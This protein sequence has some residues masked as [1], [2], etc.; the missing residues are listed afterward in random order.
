MS[1]SGDIKDAS[2]RQWLVVE[3]G[4]TVTT[5]AFLATLAE[6]LV[7][8]GLPVDRMLLSVRT[9]HP[10][11][12]ATGYLWNAGH[13]VVEVD[14]SYDILNAPEYL[15][16]PFRMIHEG[17]ARVRR[18]LT[19]P[20]AC[21][22]MPLMTELVREGFTDYVGLQFVMS[23]GTRDAISMATRHPD[24]FTDEQID[25]L[26][27]LTPIISLIVDRQSG[28]RTARTLLDTYVGHN[29]GERILKGEIRRGM[30][31]R[32]QAVIWYGDLRNFT[33]MSDS[34]PTDEVIATLDEYFELMT[35]AVHSH[36]G[37]VLKYIGDGIL[38]IFEIGD[39]AFRHYACRQA[40]AAA[41]EV[42]EGIAALNRVRDTEG[43]PPLDFGLGLH[44]GELV[45]GNIGSLDRLDFTV[46]G[47]AV[48]LTSRL[49][50]LSSQLG[51]TIL[52]SR[53]FADT[54]STY[55]PFVSLGLHE[56]RGV[57]EPQEVFTLP[58]HAA[59]RANV[60][61]AEAG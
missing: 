54:A 49:E 58:R 21:I 40:L 19:G 11:I 42:E 26:Q 47:P 23:D 3:G 61:C 18:R 29:A 31:Q 10:Q 57:R 35:S 20:N 9:I 30:G 46:I 43:K 37:Q 25:F 1:E 34:L 2:F 48:N 32:I 60:R 4:R 28:E 8:H 13:D 41:T 12:L 59:R 24:G 36:G 45:Y 39:A 55:Q 15:D 33:A 38:A 51:V 14:R 7:A 17:A 22:D 50:A 16:S 56:L 44:V 53:E 6:G 5:R 52:T 27:T